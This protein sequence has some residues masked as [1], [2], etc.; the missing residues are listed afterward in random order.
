MTKKQKG[1]T[2][3]NGEWH[4]AMTKVAARASV[5]DMTQFVKFTESDV[6]KASLELARK[7]R[8]EMCHCNPTDP[9]SDLEVEEW[10][11]YAFLA[12]AAWQRKKDEE[13]ILEVTPNQKG[14]QVDA[15]EFGI[16][17]AK[18]IRDGSFDGDKTQAYVAVNNPKETT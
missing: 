1:Y 4:E 8:Y 11:G 3:E 10:L 6:K 16:L 12:G 9:F 14:Y 7:Y 13:L 2:D 5:E 17:L 15:R 18:G